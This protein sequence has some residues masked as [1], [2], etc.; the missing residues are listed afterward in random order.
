MLCENFLQLKIKT[1]IR[2]T[3][4]GCITAK[5]VGMYAGGNCKVK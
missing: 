1:M 2:V 4:C 5:L 3:I